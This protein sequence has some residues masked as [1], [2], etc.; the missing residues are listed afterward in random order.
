MSHKH[1]YPSVSH[2]HGRHILV[3]SA[4]ESQRQWHPW[5]LLASQ[6]SLLSELQEEA[7]RFL[8]I[9][10]QSGLLVKP[11]VCVCLCM[12]VIFLKYILYILIYIIYKTK[13]K[14]KK[15]SSLFSSLG[16]WSLYFNSAQCPTNYTAGPDCKDGNLA[17][18]SGGNSGNLGIRER[19][20]FRQD[21]CWFN[22]VVSFALESLN[23]RIKLC[24]S[25]L[26][27][28]SL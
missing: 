23:T 9:Q 6:P 12:Y 1:G 27:R 24:E 21:S 11:C 16:M 28:L 26:P 13:T 22:L 8:W 18:E 20:A 2:R 7:G 4:L 3:I 15:K 14:E 17:L 19:E 25:V 5:S 10:G